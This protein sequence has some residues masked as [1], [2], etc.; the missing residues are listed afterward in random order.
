MFLCYIERYMESRLSYLSFIISSHHRIWMTCRELD[1]LSVISIPYDPHSPSLFLQWWSTLSST[2]MSTLTYWDF[3]SHEYNTIVRKK[4]E[5][6]IDVHWS[7]IKSAY[8]TKENCEPN[9][10]K[11]KGK[12]GKRCSREEYHHHPLCS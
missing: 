6:D 10:A 1:Q 9:E 3:G 12:A 8:V 2:R 7:L 11:G 4:S 5:C